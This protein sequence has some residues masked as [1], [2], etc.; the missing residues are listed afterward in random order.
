MEK[1]LDDIELFFCTKIAEL[2][3]KYGCI[4]KFKRKTIPK[5]VRDKVW[6]TYIGAEL[7]LGKCYCC[8]TKIDS[9][10][11]DCGHVIAVAMG[12]LNTVE[13]LRPVCAT[14]N[15]S[16]GIQNLE[17]FKTEFFRKKRKRWCGFF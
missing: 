7:G 17:D 10:N 2:K 15:K 9:K 16:M 8:S 12:G 1:D 3:K 5:T 13:N 11:F 14:C 6:N 4:G